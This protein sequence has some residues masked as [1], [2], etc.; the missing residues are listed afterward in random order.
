MKEKSLS[1]T[2]AVMKRFTFQVQM[3]SE[4]FSGRY[5]CKFIRT[6]E[7]VYW[8]KNSTPTGLIWNTNMSA[9]TSCEFFWRWS[10][11]SIFCIRC[12][13]KHDI[14]KYLIASKTLKN[15]YVVVQF[16]VFK[17]RKIQFTAENSNLP[18]TWSN[19]CFPLDHLYI[20][21]PSITRTTFWALKKSGKNSVLA[22]E[23]L[24][25]DFP[26]DVL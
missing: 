10:F 8:E 13:G 3:S 21:L 1:H 7:N 24:N 4:R 25:F 14:L 12:L 9:L 2:F 5:L 19:F 11:H 20:L 16:W 26:I 17:Q 18:L 23:T 15:G 6:R 22:S